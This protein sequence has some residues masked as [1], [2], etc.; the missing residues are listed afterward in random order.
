MITKKKTL[1]KFTRTTMIFVKKYSLEKRN[2]HTE[3]DQN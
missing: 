3:A 2:T 1:L